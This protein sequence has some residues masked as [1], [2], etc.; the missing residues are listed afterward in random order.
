MSHGLL[1]PKLGEHNVICDIS[2]RKVRSDKV[3]KTWENLIVSREDYD[4]KHPQLTLRAREERIAVTPTRDRPADK[5][6][7]E[8]DPDS[9]NQR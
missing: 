8:V 6:V 5:F 2:G 3:M 7:T 9:L 4:P 1:N